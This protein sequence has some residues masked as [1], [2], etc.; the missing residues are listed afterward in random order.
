MERNPASP[1]LAVLPLL[2]AALLCASLTTQWGAE[3]CYVALVPFAY[4][5]R[6][7]ALPRAT[8][9]AAYLAGLAVHLVGMSWVLDCYR[10]EN[11]V[12]PY[13]VQWFWIGTWGG[14][15]FVAAFALGRVL[16]ARSRLPMTVLLPLL[17]VTYEFIRHEMAELIT[18]TGFP[19]LKLGTALLDS[20]YLVQ[21]ADLGGEYLLSFLVA[22]VSGTL[23][24]LF[25]ALSPNRMEKFW[26]APVSCLVLCLVMIASTGYGYWRVHQPS[27]NEGPTVVL[28]GELD[29]PPL[30]P[31]ERLREATGTRH[32]D[33]LLWPELA[34]HHTIR[35]ASIKSSARCHLTHSAKE[36]GCTLVIGCKRIQGAN[37]YNSLACAD[38]TEGFQGCYDKINLV[39]G[40]E[41]PMRGTEL[42]DA[43]NFSY[44]RGQDLRVFRLPTKTG[45]Y[46]FAPA[47][48]YDLCFGQHFRKS[49]TQDIDFLVQC[50]AEGQDKSDEVARWMLRYA[51]LRAI[52]NRRSLVRN[53]T[54]GYSALIDGNGVVQVALTTDPITSPTWLGAVPIDTRWSFY[55]YWGDWIAYVACFAT[56]GLALTRFRAKPQAAG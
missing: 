28:M 19:W 27:G 54:F 14:A 38:S 42:F 17:W 40:A 39:P 26:P 55:A 10:Y 9:A 50:G 1:T 45:V 13:A 4:A 29:L 30:L 46:R 25:L 31:P 12:G 8:Y 24:D 48:C 34:Y 2:T 32:A 47:I 41:A 36:L 23:V 44:Q 11:A 33:L 51:R 20:R 5:L 37:S 6:A 35:D 3:L 7:S 43:S 15:L 21:I 53:A 18:G 16:A 49:Q 22:M 52:E 56:M